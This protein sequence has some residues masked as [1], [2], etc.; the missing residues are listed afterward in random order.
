MVQKIS[1]VFFLFI[2]FCIF[3]CCNNDKSSQHQVYDTLN[4]KN[5]PD[6]LGWDIEVS[7]VD[8][9]F[10][11][12]VLSAK[13]ARVYYDRKETF[14]DDSLKVIFY[15]KDSKQRQSVLTADS[16]K[17]DDRSR[18]MLAFGNVIVWADS[19]KTKLET[20][21]LLWDNKNQKLYST[22][23]VKISS[24][25]ENLQ[26]WGFESDLSLTNYK[27]FKVSGVQK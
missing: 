6:H 7:F 19:S 9:N 15:S 25:K 26:G 12:A 21:L 16:A 5:D 14:L 27:I 10:T 2:I 17:I 22:E 1:S 18:D 23:F 24:P 11:K 8:S 13:T 3:I 4:Y 20:S